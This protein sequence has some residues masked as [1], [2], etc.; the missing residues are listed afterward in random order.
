MEKKPKKYIILIIV[1]VCCIAILITINVIGAISKSISATAEEENIIPEVINP[2]LL[3]NGDFMLNTSNQTEWTKTGK[4]ID[5]WNL[6]TDSTNT[7]IQYNGNYILIWQGEQTQENGNYINFYQSLDITISGNYTL[8]IQT[9]NTNNINQIYIKDLII[10]NKYYPSK[11]ITNQNGKI[12]RRLENLSPTK[13]E[14]GIQLKINPENETT[15]KLYY[16]KFENGDISTAPYGL[17]N[18]NDI[19]NAGFQEGYEDGFNNGSTINIIPNP[20]FK[21]ENNTSS[22]Y[23]PMKLKDYNSQQSESSKIYFINNWNYGCNTNPNS[24][25]PSIHGSP[26][27]PIYYNAE[28]NNLTLGISNIADNTTTLTTIYTNEINIAEKQEDVKLNFIYTTDNEPNEIKLWYTY[29]SNKED[30]DNYF[31]DTNNTATN[32]PNYCTI[33]NA[34]KTKQENTYNLS[35]SIANLDPNKYIFG[36][37]IKGNNPES[38]INAKNYTTTTLSNDETIN[39]YDQGYQNGY[40]TGYNKGNS[41]G[42]NTGY[43]NGYKD[44]YKEGDTNGYNEGFNKGLIEGKGPGTTIN[45]L[46]S[47]VQSALNVKL[48]GQISLQDLLNVMLA[49]TF[50]VV[51]L[52]VFAGG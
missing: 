31:N 23:Y 10:E 49:V 45:S 17:T 41:N 6:S 1:A 30:L 21:K 39:I 42:L 29:S 13:I 40:E 25:I 9:D 15:L 36:F 51:A 50:V 33:L 37:Y 46:I 5:N 38:Y 52:K 26:F 7:K 14:I 19:Y 47:T 27:F 16:A 8:T 18:P 3:K 35:A 48:F 43:N 2:N 24:Y 4:T 11:T 12:I 32:L 28:T 22:I 20:N 34:T 44:G